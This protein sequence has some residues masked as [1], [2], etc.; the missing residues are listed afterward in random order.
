[1]N[2]V[3]NYNLIPS[4]H[5]Y[6]FLKPYIYPQ[7]VILGGIAHFII[8]FSTQFKLMVLYTDVV[9]KEIWGGGVTEEEVVNVEP[10][11]ARWVIYRGHY[12]KHI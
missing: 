12:L 7:S 6:D 10:C 9:G 2:F 4:P 1:M 11:F 3:N 8:V 5:N